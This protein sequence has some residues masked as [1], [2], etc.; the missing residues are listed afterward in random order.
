MLCVSCSEGTQSKRQVLPEQ[1]R[2]VFDV[3]NDIHS[4]AERSNPFGHSY[5]K[6]PCVLLWGTEAVPSGRVAFRQASCRASACGEPVHEQGHPFIQSPVLHVEKWA[7][8][9]AAA[10]HCCGHQL[11]L[12]FCLRSL[13]ISSVC[14]W[15]LHAIAPL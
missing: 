5:K 15:F 8:P 12:T 3:D 9:R 6:V 7:F 2:E 11:H 14:I 10:W 4:C 1:S 13:G